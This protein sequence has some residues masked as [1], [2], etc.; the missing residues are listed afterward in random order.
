MPTYSES[1][2]SPASLQFCV[3]FVQALFH[4][5]HVQYTLIPVTGWQDLGTAFMEHKDQVIQ[6]ISAFNRC[7]ERRVSI[8]STGRFCVVSF[9]RL[10]Q[11]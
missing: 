3:C 10:N 4:C 1:C 9:E 7:H 8:Y 11:V 6:D 5:D 2:D